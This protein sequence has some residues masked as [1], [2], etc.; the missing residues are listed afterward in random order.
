MTLSPYLFFDGTCEA[1]F[2]HYRSVFGG[3]YMMMM[4][5]ADGPEEYR[6]GG[7]DDQKIMHVSLPI[8]SAVL[9]GSD[10]VG[11]HPKP[12]AP[13]NSFSVNVAVETRAEADRVHAGLADGGEVTMPMDEVFWGSY[14]GM[15]QDRF[16]VSW[17]VNC[18]G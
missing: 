11:D 2:E 12:G 7:P 4:R 16:G 3:E 15:C 1:A 18:D 17:M 10:V 9:M 13:N 6:S 14:F 8:G 5:V